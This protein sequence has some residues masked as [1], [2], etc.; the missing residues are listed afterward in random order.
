M[1]FMLNPKSLGSGI[2]APRLP[3]KPG[4]SRIRRWSCHSGAF[5]LDSCACIISLTAK[6]SPDGPSRGARMSKLSSHS[7][8]SLFY[9]SASVPDRM[10]SVNRNV[11]VVLIRT[12]SGI[13]PPREAPEARKLPPV[14]D[15]PSNY[16]SSLK[17][18]LRERNFLMEMWF[19]CGNSHQR[20][21]PDQESC[22]RAATM[23][24]C[25]KLIL[26]RSG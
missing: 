15:F 6:K 17:E 9:P 20:N 8:E 12:Q 1:R 2:I 13:V 24:K 25:W 7:S 22:K 5:A 23:R 16:G 18:W 19:S 21:M 3:E 26:K 4:Y 10:S 11:F 14:I